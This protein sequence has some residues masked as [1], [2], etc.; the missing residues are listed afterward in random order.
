MRRRG[1]GQHEVMFSIVV[2]EEVADALLLHEAADEIEV[3]LA[4]LDA[5]FPGLVGLGQA[6]IVIGEAVL[7]KGILDDVRDGLLLEDA[8]IARPCEQP[9]P[10]HQFGLVAGIA[11]PD[12]QLAKPADDAMKI[13]VA[14]DAIALG[15]TNAARLTD[16]SVKVELRVLAHQLHQVAERAGDFFLARHGSHDQ[17]AFAQG[18]V[19]SRRAK[20]LR[21]RHKSEPF[22]PLERVQA[23]RWTRVKK[24]DA[25]IDT[26]S[27]PTYCEETLWLPLLLVP[28]PAAPP[29]TC[30]P[31]SQYR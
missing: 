13:P 4:V 11:I 6:Q 7:A 8:T 18:T 20:E 1:V 2:P 27:R 19:E 22:S 29:M 31:P 30:N 3:R 16:E 12:W 10:G 25:R 9:Q 21:D 5:V 17:R 23:D 14:T 28:C 24:K 26:E 15:Q